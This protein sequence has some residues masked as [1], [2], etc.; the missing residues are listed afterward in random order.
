MADTTGRGEV[1][2]PHPE[3]LT[4]QD[5]DGD[6]FLHITVAQGR[7]A[8]AYV[9]ASKMATVG[10]LDMKE[11]NGQTIQRALKGK[12]QELNVEEVNYD[13]LTPLQ[14]AVRSHNAVVQELGHMAAPPSPWGGGVDSEKEATGAVCQHTAAHGSLL[15][16]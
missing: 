13:G 9:L 10:M 11:H 12:G 6:T 8:L 15:C 1:G 2:R 16:N 4:S 7:R 3:M 14:T 5:N